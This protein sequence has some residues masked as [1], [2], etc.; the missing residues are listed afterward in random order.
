MN[1]ADYDGYVLD[2]ETQGIMGNF[3]CATLYNPELDAL[4]TYTELPPFL[5]QL[6]AIEGASIW[7]HNVSYEYNYTKQ[8]GIDVSKYKWYC[9]QVLA[10]CVD[11]ANKAERSSLD[12]LTSEYCPEQRKLDFTPSVPWERFTEEC[13]DW[14]YMVE[15]NRKD[16]VAT[17]AL[18]ESLLNSVGS[19]LKLAPSNKEIVVARMH[20]KLKDYF[21]NIRMPFL[22]KVLIPAKAHGLT[23]DK[24]QVQKIIDLCNS[25]TEALTEYTLPTVVKGTP[26]T[27]AVR[28][29]RFADV[30]AAYTDDDGV[31]RASD[32]TTL[33]ERCP[34]KRTRLTS[35]TDKSIAYFFKLMGLTKHIDKETSN[36]DVA[37]IDVNT[38]E[39]YLRDMVYG[40]FLSTTDGY[41][42]SYFKHAV[43]IDN[44][45]FSIHSYFN[46]NGTQT[47]R[48][49][50]S[51]PNLQNIG[52]SKSIA[53]PDIQSIYKEIRKIVVA[54]DGYTFISADFDRIELTILSKVLE[55]WD[56]GL[57]DTLNAN[58]DVH[59]YNAD[60]WGLDRLTAKRLIFSLVYGA[61]EHKVSEIMGCSL[62]KA[63]QV[64]KQIFEGMPALGLA[65]AKYIKQCHQ[66]GG[67]YDLFG[68]FKNY[69]DIFAPEKWRVAKVERQLFNAVMQG[70]N[71][72]MIAWYT[73]QMVDILSSFG[74]TLTAIVHDEMLAEVP[75]E[76]VEACVAALNKLTQ[77]RYDIPGLEGCRVNADWFSGNSWAETK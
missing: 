71:A 10:H 17:V 67:V 5:E 59:Q 8:L 69:P 1:Y 3:L 35:S 38:T 18:K 2:Y 49:S 58:E 9:T 13:E 39:P 55:P 72:S 62:S 34:V 74:G 52:G 27:K 63:K 15:Y 30:V 65:M 41:M 22:I 20:T 75:I 47:G 54:R 61:R 6:R 11:K 31:V 44:A 73:P 14:E 24:A 64:L 19:H 77:E 46:I 40:S 36:I 43:P 57:R 21:F 29:G 23:M 4:A 32:V 45:R 28:K 60:K 48:L 42:K 26:V 70:T 16:V 66:L 33:Y 50:S 68:D 25:Y 37:T 51:S 53:N 56:S 12:Y 76:S 7:A